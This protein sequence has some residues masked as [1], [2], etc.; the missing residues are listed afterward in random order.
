MIPLLLAGF[1]LEWTVAAAQVPRHVAVDTKKVNMTMT[2]AAVQSGAILGRQL[3]DPDTCGYV[4]R[5]TRITFIGCCDENGRSCSIYNTCY[6]GSEQSKL[7]NPDSSTLICMGTDRFCATLTWPGGKQTAFSCAARPTKTQLDPKPT[8]TSTQRTSEETNSSWA[9][10]DECIFYSV[11][12]WYCGCHQTYYTTTVD[13]V[14]FAGSSLPLRQ[15]RFMSPGKPPTGSPPA[16]TPPSSYTP[17]PEAT[18]SASDKPPVLP[19]GSGIMQDEQRVGREEHR[20]PADGSVKSFG[21]EAAGA[22][23]WDNSTDEL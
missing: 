5:P 15:P 8:P 12:H 16:G 1:F 9:P 2:A 14:H 20:A 3:Q 18:P 21:H 19:L 6:P 17:P 23:R 10:L 22:P 7:S 4:A 11:F 13:I